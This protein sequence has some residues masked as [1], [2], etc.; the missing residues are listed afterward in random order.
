[1]FET[2]LI[3]AVVGGVIWATGGSL[4]KTKGSSKNT[5]LDVFLQLIIAIVL[6]SYFE[7]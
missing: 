4:F 6:L 3:L 5:D 1:M 2:L 7:F